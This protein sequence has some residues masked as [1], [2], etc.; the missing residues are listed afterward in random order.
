MTVATA[1]ALVA[2][3]VAWVHSSPAPTAPATSSFTTVPATNTTVHSNTAV[4]ASTA[5]HSVNSAS[6]PLRSSVAAS[7]RL[8]I[9][10]A[11]VALPL[12]VEIP[13]IGV[14]SHLLAVGM[15]ASHAMAAPQGNGASSYWGDTFWYRGSAVPGAVGTATIA[16]HIDDVY[17][18]YAVFGR[19]ASLVKGERIT[20]RNTKTGVA[21]HFKVT[22]VHEYSLAQSKTTKVLDLIYGLGP[23]Q[24][25]AAQPSRD[26]LAHLSLVSCVGT[27][28]QSLKTHNG[29]LVVSA[30]R[31]R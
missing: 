26:G 19:L 30:V 10:A 22:A 25:R 31:V 17:G 12:V 20:I 18:R 5:V 4:H 3:L 2:V 23:P 27:W 15:T 13:S 11:P 14:H 24:G 29:R 1:T 21:E 6:A 16:G 28:V 9:H 8:N 7:L